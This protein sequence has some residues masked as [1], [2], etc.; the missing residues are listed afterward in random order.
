VRANAASNV[1]IIGNACSRLGEV[2]IYAEFG[3][4]GALIACNLIDTAAS[5]IAVTNFN[6]GGRLAVVQGNLVRG[7]FRREQEP[8]DKRGVG[9]SVEADTLVTGNTIESAE[10]CGIAVGWGSYLRDCAISQNL[11]RK[12]PVGILVS[13]DPAAGQALVSGNMI[14]DTPDGAIRFMDGAGA[15]A[16]G[17]LAS[18]ADRKGRITITGN[19]VSGAQSSGW[20]NWL[21]RG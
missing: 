10:S 11:V 19:I 2:A 3:F 16:G 8:E 20:L 9:I 6:D 4:E 5:G 21:S 15:P 7:L 1:Q 17:D 12:T 14:A 13:D 18:E